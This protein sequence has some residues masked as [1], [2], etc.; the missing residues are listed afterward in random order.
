MKLLEVL[1]ERRG[2]VV[3]REQLRNRVRPDENF[4]DFDQVF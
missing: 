3:T 4:G 1:L 2:E